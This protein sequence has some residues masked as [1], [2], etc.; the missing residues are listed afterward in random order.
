MF[1]ESHAKDGKCGL[2]RNEGIRRF[3]GKLV[4]KPTL[5]LTFIVLCCMDF[6]S[7][8][9]G[10]LTIVVIL[11]EFVCNCYECGILLYIN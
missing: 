7:S 10:C 2:S 4:E 8:I 9:D 3:V 6:I 11:C 1:L 5:V